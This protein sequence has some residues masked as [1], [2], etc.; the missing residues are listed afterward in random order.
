M[1]I[2]NKVHN[3][4]IL[5][6]SGSMFPIKEQILRGFNEIV[7]TVKGVEAQ[8]PEQEHFISFIS[9]NGLGI[10]EQLFNVPVKN[11]QQLDANGYKPAATTP[12][13]DAI[14]YG[15]SKLEKILGG[16]NDHNVLVSILTDG[17][18]NY[19]REYTRGTIKAKIEELKSKRWTFT[20]TGTGHDVHSAAGAL[21][22]K[23]VV[24]FTRDEAAMEEMFLQE[25]TARL[26]Y[27]ASIRSGKIT[28]EN[29][30]SK[31]S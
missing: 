6:E 25:S 22:I 1:K 26:N 8:Y 30:Y 9:F 18:E 13:Y 29:F 11:L 15:I 28:D 4:I 12:L 3:L 23:N 14:G 31:G 20:Y 5:D 24:Q 27:S 19:S 2:K 10:T 21:S 17:E 7:Q 16:N